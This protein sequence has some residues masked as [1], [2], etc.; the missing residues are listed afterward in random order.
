MVVPAED[1]GR[2]AERKHTVEERARIVGA[3]DLV[4]HLFP[5]FAEIIPDFIAPRL[6]EL[7][8]GPLLLQRNV[9]ED[10]RRHSA[11]RLFIQALNLGGVPFDLIVVNIVIDIDSLAGVGI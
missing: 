8:C 7:V 10:Q 4:D 2:A 6:I 5:I 3:A 9:E 1:T 11:T